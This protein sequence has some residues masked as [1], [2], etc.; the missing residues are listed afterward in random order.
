MF[1]ILKNRVFE[2]EAI[3]VSAFLSFDEVF[4]SISI[5]FIFNLNCSFSSESKLDN[6]PFINLNV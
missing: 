4:G 3:M 1:S 6:C 2:I 5:S